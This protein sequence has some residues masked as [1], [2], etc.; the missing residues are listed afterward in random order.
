MSAIGR[1][2]PGRF[3]DPL[4]GLRMWRSGDYAAPGPRREEQTVAY[5]NPLDG[6][7]ITRDAGSYAVEHIICLFSEPERNAAVIPMLDVDRR[8]TVCF[9]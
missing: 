8:E 1:L 7:K 2:S 4:A 9:E 3:W 5:H 6:I